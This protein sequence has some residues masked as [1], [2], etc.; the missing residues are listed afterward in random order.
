LQENGQEEEEEEERGQLDDT[1]EQDPEAA[2]E[3]ETS[4]KRRRIRS[5]FLSQVDEIL[6]HCSSGNDG[7]NA[8]NS[9]IFTFARIIVYS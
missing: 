8:A 3:K 6:S 2:E 4:K 5:S 7:D 9:S 1:E